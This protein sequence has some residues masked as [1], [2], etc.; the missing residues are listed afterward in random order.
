MS[1]PVSPVELRSDTFTRPTS[2]M[3]VAMMEA[4][5][6]DNVWGE[7]PSVEALEVHTAA[8]FGKE[9][10]LYCP[11]GTM[12]NQVSLVAHLRPGE[13]VICA[14][15]AHIHLYEGGG[16][17]AN[18][19]ASTQLL[20]SDRGRFTATQVDEAIYP[21]DPHVPISTVVAIED[22]ANR[23]GGAIWDTREVGAI[24]ELCRRRGLKF[25]L[26]GARVM[27]RLVAT[28]ECPQ[29][30][31]SHFDSISI[32]LSKGLG[33]PMGS[34]L[35]GSK[36]FIHQ[37]E[38]IRKRM[39]GGM[40]QAGYMAAAGLYALV[41]HV[42]RLK[43]DHRHATQLAKALLAHSDVVEV[44]PTETNIVLFRPAEGELRRWIDTLA[45]HGVKAAPLGPWIRFVTHLGVSQQ[46][47]ARVVMVLEQL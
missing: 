36:D 21:D 38:R 40:R 10:G 44:L 19:G 6:G 47:I 27:N 1:S 17:S 46:D 13:S 5:V 33:A 30:Y 4:E 22:T 39:G 37:A 2:P 26:D 28:G 14:D 9:A 42:D 31:G 16:I 43:E 32:C 34:V 25:H 3:M 20:R 23:G 18:A 45:E 11:S 8:M 24:A 35:L 29:Q 7:D 15:T 12:S 41:N